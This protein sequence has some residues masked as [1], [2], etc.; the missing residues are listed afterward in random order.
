LDPNHQTEDDSS[1][2]EDDEHGIGG[3]PSNSRAGISV[4]GGVT[5]CGP[6]EVHAA[7]ARRA[8]DRAR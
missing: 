7:A 2:D 8:N 3:R 1:E 5:R 6:G 4:S